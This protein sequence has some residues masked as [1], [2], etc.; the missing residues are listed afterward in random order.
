MAH[1]VGAAVESNL[2]DF[3]R[4][5]VLPVP[6]GYDARWQLLHPDDAI[7]ALVAVLGEAHGRHLHDLCRG[8]DD[9]PVVP[10]LQAKSVGHEQTFVVDLTEP[11]EID[12]EL[13]RL[14]DAVSIR[15]RGS[16]LAARVITVKVR[17]PAF[18]TVSRS[19]TVPTPIDDGDSL[20]GLARRL[21]STLDLRSGV[22]LLGVST[23]GL[24]DAGAPRQL[25]FDVGGPARSDVPD[26]DERERARLSAVDEIRARFGP[27]AIGRARHVRPGAAG[28]TRPGEQPWGPSDRARD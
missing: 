27:D 23:S 1:I 18:D 16:G 7:A 3:L 22:R 6:F 13:V 20:A 9:R 5:P 10:D 26:L 15:L 14:A 24:G 2:T 28:A 4:A 25:A 12:S 11:G 8:I 21:V 19:V 17:D